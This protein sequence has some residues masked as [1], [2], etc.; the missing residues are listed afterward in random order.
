MPINLEQQ[1]KKLESE[2][3]HLEQQLED[4]KASASSAE[5]KREST[6]FGKR[7]EGAN[8]AQDLERRL[9]LEK[10]VKNQQV[11][12]ERALKKIEEGSYGKCDGCGKKI[13]PARLEA[14]PQAA[15]C[16][17]CKTKLSQK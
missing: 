16:M 10:R 8:E 17:E 14:L 1:R 12:I 6:P 11:A 5:E 4:L 9:T 2:K 15:L 13:D 3:Q 7:D